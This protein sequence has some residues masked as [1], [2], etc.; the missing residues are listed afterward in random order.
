MLDRATGHAMDA[1]AARVV[2][3]VLFTSFL[4]LVGFG[5]IIPLLP[6]YVKSMGGTAETVGILL[7]CFSFT[8]LVATPLLGRLSDSAGR[9]RVI[10]VSLAGNAASMVLF[11]AASFWHALPL[12]F[13]SRT[14]A[15]ATA[16]NLAAC[17]AAVADVT[18]GEAR[19]QGMGRI[20]AGI[21]LGLVLGPAI[22]GWASA[23]GPA[24]PPLF[25]AG[26]ACLD[27]LASF[28]W[29]PETL[30]PGTSEK[31]AARVGGWRGLRNLLADP[32]I[33]AVLALSFFTFL[34]M[35]NMQVALPLL[36]SSRWKWGSED[37]GHVFALY[38]LVGLITQGFLIG[39][40]T[41]KYGAKGLVTGGA[42]ASCA[43]LL[44]VAFARTTPIAVF[45][46]FLIA[47]GVG[48][49][50]PVLSTLASE[51]AGP[52]RQG[53]VLGVTQ[54]AGGLARTVGPMASGALYARV[55]PAA[56][57]VGG[58]IAAIAAFVVALGL[59]RTAED[60]GE[61][62]PPRLGSKS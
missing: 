31:R 28:L 49:T 15:G 4:D 47:I 58:A 54:S 32:R 27:W 8:Q 30:H 61:G 34:Y 42:L 40:L 11:S 16:G 55:A 9:R 17:Q 18:R 53:T 14:L 43:G 23:L 45:G 21:G 57:F 12:L 3:L 1:R 20:G 44:I 25:A 51:Y 26:L 22:G 6:L 13:V 19:A 56:S 41:R 62:G 38:G 24:A 35:T 37:I 29:M 7:S 59:R 39:R 52:S 46:I 2:W 48:L 50:H 33:L 36:A 5:I 60:D 10:L